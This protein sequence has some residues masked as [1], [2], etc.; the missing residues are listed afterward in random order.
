MSLTAKEALEDI[1]VLNL[2]ELA[3]LMVITKMQVC[4]TTVRQVVTQM[5]KSL[6]SVQD[7]ENLQSMLRIIKMARTIPTFEWNAVEQ[8][9]KRNELVN[10]EKFTRKRRT[11]NQTVELFLLLK[12]FDFSELSNLEM[13]LLNQIIENIQEV[14][15]VRFLKLAQVLFSHF[16]FELTENKIN[17]TPMIVL[18]EKIS[19]DEIKNKIPTFD[20][21][22]RLACSDYDPL[23]FHSQKLLKTVPLFRSLTSQGNLPFFKI[24][25][26]FASKI[27]SIAIFNLE[28]N[29]FD[30]KD[31]SI[32]LKIINLKQKKHKIRPDENLSPRLISNME[33]YQHLQEY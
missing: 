32:I 28:K 17:D 19:L 2:K 23:K 6:A 25:P 7:K 20:I 24:L 1:S 15:P 14:E 11:V 4:P 10:V 12:E 33:I 21:L 13:D 31:L 9:F 3:D 30:K 5:S 18:L 29:L 8:L 27:V 26:E 22:E 16:L